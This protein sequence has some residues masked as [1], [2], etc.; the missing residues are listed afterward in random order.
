MFFM[1]LKN[2]FAKNKPITYFTGFG[3]A[4]KTLEELLVWPSFA[5]IHPEVQKRLIALMIIGRSNNLDIGIGRGFRFEKDQYVLFSNCHVKANLKPGSQYKVNACCLYG[6]ESYVLCS[7]MIHRDPPFHSYYEGTVSNGSKILYSV[8]ADLTGWHRLG[9][10]FF[11]GMLPNVG[12][13]L[14]NKEEPWAVMPL[15]F[16]EDRL[17]YD[18]KVHVLQDFIIKE[19]NIFSVSS[20]AKNADG[21]CH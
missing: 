18:P 17:L 5:Y 1:Y 8:A 14:I 10:D 20:A 4:R 2:K 3:T 9:S 15:E 7:D 21:I 13:K 6:G 11:A 19:F 12:L 16:P